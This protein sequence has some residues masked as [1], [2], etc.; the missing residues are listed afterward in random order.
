MW[1]TERLDRAKTISARRTV[2]LPFSL[3]SAPRIVYWL[4][5]LRE[6]QLGCLGWLPS[7]V[8]D[9]GGVDSVEPKLF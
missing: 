3:L 9:G 5:S 2:L 1:E 8:H 4:L 7:L 6:K